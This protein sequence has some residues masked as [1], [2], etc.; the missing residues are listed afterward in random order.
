MSGTTILVVEDD[1]LQATTIAKFLER[2]GHRTAQARSGVDA[3]KY[4]ETNMCDLILLDVNMPVMDGFEVC[5]RIRSIEKLKK[6]PIVFL[7]AR[8][9]TQD[10]RTGIKSG[11]DTYITKPFRNS[12]LVSAINMM[13]SMRRR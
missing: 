8:A 5:K 10:Y 1:D 7:T 3:L 12:Q 9:T 13:L 6:I 4:L 2:E 11:G